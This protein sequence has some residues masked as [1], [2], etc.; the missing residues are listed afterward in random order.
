MKMAIPE[1]DKSI[2][3]ELAKKLAE[4]A[5]LPIQQE[6]MELWRR[7]NK[8]DPVR[9]M[10]LLLNDTWHENKDEIKL[11]CEDEFARRQE[12]LLRRMLYHFEHMPDDHVYEAKIYCPIAIRVS[13]Y[14]IKPNIERPQHEFGAA[15]FNPVISERDDPSIL[16]MPEVTVDWEETERNYERLCEIYDG[17]L[18]V[19]KRGVYGHWF[20]IIDEFIQ[21]RGVENTFV[22]MIERPEWL[23]SWLERMTQ[24]HLCL[25]EQYERLGLLSLNNGPVNIGP[26]GLGV[27]DELPQ[28]DFDGV[29]VRAKDQWGHATTQIFADVSPA[30]HEE[31]A[32]RY[33]SR[34][35]SR[36][37]LSSYGCCEPLHNKLEII[38]RNI[39]NLRRISISPWADVEKAAESLGKDYIMSLKPNPSIF[40]IEQWDIELAERKLREMLE[41]ARGCVVEILMKDLHTCR[42]QP[43]RMWEWVNMAMRVVEEFAN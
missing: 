26:G 39:P 18:T 7:L 21:W 43:Q 12:W 22:D 2:L 38:K 30:M 27:T 23:H 10:V 13:S 33:E 34:F 32:L 6:K 5:S 9:P 31:F 25:L 1:R 28:P 36:F 14:G 35:L 41:K 3:R 11:E 4:I 24:W 16:K 29:H 40:S 8:L 37:G 20:A 42:K 17:I 15:R 19:E